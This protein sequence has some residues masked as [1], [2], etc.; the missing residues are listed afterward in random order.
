MVDLLPSD[1]KSNRTT[2]LKIK[3]RQRLPNMENQNAHYKTI[4]CRNISL[5]VEGEFLTNPGIVID[6][7]QKGQGYWVTTEKGNPP[8]RNTVYF[9]QSDVVGI[10]SQ[11]LSC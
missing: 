3:N 11:D 1:V 6:I 4:E 9:D 10:S 2:I 5:V 8:I 7:D